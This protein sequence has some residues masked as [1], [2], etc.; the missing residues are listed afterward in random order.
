M[1]ACQTELN[2]LRRHL[3]PVDVDHRLAAAAAAA[4]ASVAAEALRCS[5][6]RRSISRNRLSLRLRGCGGGAAFDRLNSS[7]RDFFPRRYPLDATDFTVLS[8]SP[9]SLS[10]FCL[11][12]SPP[13][14]YS[15]PSV[16]LTLVAQTASSSSSSFSC[17]SFI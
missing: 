13:S 6:R 7:I 3:Q 10:P 4:A 9:A 1:K 16:I 15:F 14:S 2:P 17:S 12:S 5:L 11:P 8:S